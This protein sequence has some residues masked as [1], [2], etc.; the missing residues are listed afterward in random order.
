[1]KKKKHNLL[2]S[3]YNS[4]YRF[5]VGLVLYASNNFGSCATN[6]ALFK[7]IE[8]LGLRPILLDSLISPFGVSLKFLKENLPVTSS[9]I[10]NNS[11]EE[12]NCLCKSF[13][14]GS[15]YSMN[16]GASHTLDHLEYLYMSFAPDSSKKIAYAPSLGNPDI[17]KIP[18]LYQILKSFYQGLIFFPLE[19]KVQLIFVKIILV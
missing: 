6:F 18:F 4:L 16:I 8:G 7:A 5:D 1:M 10:E 2:A 9:F 19:S 14:V 15:D 12:V 11:F 17:K 3:L 13:V